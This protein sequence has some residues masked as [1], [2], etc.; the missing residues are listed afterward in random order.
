M[1]NELVFHG[2][3]II[4]DN[5]IHAHEVSGWTILFRNICVIEPDIEGING[6]VSY[7]LAAL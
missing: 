5:K 4:L 6:D 1:K 3:T 2:T 7:I